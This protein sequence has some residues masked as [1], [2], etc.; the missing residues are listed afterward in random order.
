MSKRC[1]ECRI[2]K[3]IRYEKQKEKEYLRTIPF[4]QINKEKLS[5]LNPETSLFIIGNGFDLMHGIPSSY[6]NFRDS[7]G[8]NSRVKYHLETS[9]HIEDI[10]EDFE[11]NLAYLVERVCLE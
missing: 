10:W 11:N 5:L 6:Y 4:K 7:L 2:K 9:I 3:N 8:N 1:K